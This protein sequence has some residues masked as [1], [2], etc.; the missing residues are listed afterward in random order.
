[1]A[2]KHKTISKHKKLT[3]C[4]KICPCLNNYPRGG[5]GK[6]FKIFFS[7]KSHS[8]ENEPTPYPYA[9][10]N[11]LG[12]SPKP[13]NCRQPIRIEHEKPSHFVSQSES[14]TKKPFN[15]VSQSE[16]SITSPDLSANQ[17][18]VIRHPRALGLGGGPFSALGSSRLAIIYLNTWAA[19]PPPPSD[20]LTTLLL[21]PEIEIFCEN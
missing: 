13:M 9:M 18:R 2:F 10:P 21:I 1:M 3:A 7:K 11:T 16:P 15:F 14:S 17:N 8:A 20:L 5:L 19:P 6:K 4:V 12:F